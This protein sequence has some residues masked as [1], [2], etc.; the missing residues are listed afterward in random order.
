MKIELRPFIMI[1]KGCLKH[2]TKGRWVHVN[3]R[4]IFSNA[5]ATPQGL[6]THSGKICQLAED[7]QPNLA[8]FTILC[9]APQ[10]AKALVEIYQL[11][12]ERSWEPNRDISVIEL[13][14]ILENSIQ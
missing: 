10:M 2:T 5:K 7:E 6:M 4:F 11:I 12:E 14:K 13:Q 8:N 3:E 9:R 1:L